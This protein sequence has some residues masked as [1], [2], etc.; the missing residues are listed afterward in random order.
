MLNIKVH[1]HP[2]L[3][4]TDHFRNPVA[5][6]GSLE[7]KYA[8][9]RQDKAPGAPVPHTEEAPIQV[10]SPEHTYIRLISS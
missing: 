5:G 3:L 8:A 7:I 1:L 6:E 10:G 2:Q 9:G 4:L